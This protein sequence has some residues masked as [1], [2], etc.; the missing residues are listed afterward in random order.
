M[1]PPLEPS[2]VLRLHKWPKEE[3]QGDIGMVAASLSKDTVMSVSFRDPTPLLEMLK[4]LPYVE[5]ATE[6]V[7]GA[8]ETPDATGV[9]KQVLEPAGSPT[10]RYRLVFKSIDTPM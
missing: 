3:A 5:E 2:I 7:A 4:Q 10:T 9:P 6:D 1:P 8:T